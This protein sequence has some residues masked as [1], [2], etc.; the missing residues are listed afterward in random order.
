M[1]RPP[2][3]IRLWKKEPAASVTQKKIKLILVREE[4]TASRGSGSKENLLRM[5]PSEVIATLIFQGLYYAKHFFPLKVNL[6][7]GIWNQL[8][9]DPSKLHSFISLRSCCTAMPRGQT[10]LTYYFLF[11]NQDES[12]S[13]GEFYKGNGEQW[14]SLGPHNWYTMAI[15]ATKELGTLGDGRICSG[16]GK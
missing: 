3:S 2:R 6:F 1:P 16:Q 12:E 8:I 13:V 15:S 4:Q 9:N 7:I 5:V 14:G 11:I 10:F